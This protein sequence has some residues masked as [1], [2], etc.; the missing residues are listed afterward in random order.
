MWKRS[1]LK[2]K[3]LFKSLAPSKRGALFYL[4]FFGAL[5]LFALIFGSNLKQRLFSFL[6][7]FWGLCLS[8]FYWLPALWERKYTYGDLFMK[9]LYR[10]HFPKVKQLF[11][12]DLLN[13]QSGQV[14]NVP[15]QIGLIHLLAIIWAASLLLGKKL[16]GKEKK[17]T[18]FCLM[19][20]G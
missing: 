11:W 16:K 19:I 14:H 15:V 12:P 18:L 3:T 1:L 2:L 10:E 20:F 13:S 7:L 6:S 17:L 5:V 9:D 4:S 8:A